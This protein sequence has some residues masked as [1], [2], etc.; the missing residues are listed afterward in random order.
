MRQSCKRCG[1]GQAVD[2]AVCVDGFA[3]GF[4]SI[5]I[6]A[7]AQML[8]FQL[9]GYC[10]VIAETCAVRQVRPAPRNPLYFAAIQPFAMETPV[11]FSGPRAAW[12]MER[13]THRFSIGVGIGTTTLETGAVSGGQRR[14]LVEKE[15][16]GIARAHYRPVTV[17]ES[18]PAANPLLAGPASPRVKQ[19]GC[20]IVNPATT[21]A[22]YGAPRRHC[23]DLAIR[24]N[25]VLQ[26]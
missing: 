1:W 25:P 17:V 4:Q 18:K 22:H 2:H 13:F 15:K 20:R 10:A 19:P 24:Q 6:E 21:I 16:F 26:R 9:H 5:A 11:Q 3:S 12:Q 14:H 23:D 7:P 8:P